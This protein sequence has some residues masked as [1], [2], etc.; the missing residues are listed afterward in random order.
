MLIYPPAP[1]GQQAQ[2]AIFPTICF[3]PQSTIPDI[4]DNPLSTGLRDCLLLVQRASL[5]THGLAFTTADPCELPLGSS[6]GPLK[7]S[8]NNKDSHSNRT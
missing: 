2:K 1:W 7:S 3:N 5:G 6:W 4:A 8:K